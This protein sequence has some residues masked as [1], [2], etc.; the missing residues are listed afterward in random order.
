MSRVV[1]KF[2]GPAN[3]FEEVRDFAILETSIG[4][5]V[6]QLLLRLPFNYIDEDMMD[7]LTELIDAGNDRVRTDTLFIKGAAS[8]Y[9]RLL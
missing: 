9:I 3:V 2:A 8:A 4:D 1:R 6:S 5:E 7:T